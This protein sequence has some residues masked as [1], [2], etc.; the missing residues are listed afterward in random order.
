M[1]QRHSTNADRWI[2]RQQGSSI[3]A[4]SRRAQFPEV[5][6]GLQRTV[7]PVRLRNFQQQSRASVGWPKRLAD[8]CQTYVVRAV[9]LHDLSTSAGGERQ[10]AHD[11]YRCQRWSRRY[12]SNRRDRSHV[13]DQS[14]HSELHT[15][16]GCPIRGYSMGLRQSTNAHEARR[17]C[18]GRALHVPA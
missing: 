15:R 5:D 17:E 18:D 13:C 2:F 16:C 1:Q 7:R 10:P 12:D 6:S 9:F 4:E 11:D 14:E 8:Q 3:V